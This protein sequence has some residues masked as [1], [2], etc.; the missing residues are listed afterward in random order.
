VLS[1][2]KCWITGELAGLGMNSQQ[3][4]CFEMCVFV[5]HMM[6]PGCHEG[7]SL[8]Y[9]I[10]NVIFTSDNG[11]NQQFWYLSMYKLFSRPEKVT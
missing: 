5:I 11:N 4:Q 1:S 10:Q 9:E 8:Q 7:Q 2:V 6:L 3:L